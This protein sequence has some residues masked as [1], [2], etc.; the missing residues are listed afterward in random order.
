MQ[1]MAWSFKT[2]MLKGLEQ[3]TKYEEEYKEKFDVDLILS[4]IHYAW[5]LDD[6]E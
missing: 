5:I 1:E 4:W 6:A 2:R 3:Y